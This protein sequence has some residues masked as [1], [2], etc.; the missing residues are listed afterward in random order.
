[1]GV[2]TDFGKMLTGSGNGKPSA[3]AMVILFIG[4]SCINLGIWGETKMEQLQLKAK[5]EKID[6]FDYGKLIFGF[7][8]VLG[9]TLAPYMS[10]KYNKYDDDVAAHRKS[11]TEVIPNPAPAT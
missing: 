5:H 9:G 8:G 4:L 3:R 10:K 2:E 6:G 1:M 11:N 7:F